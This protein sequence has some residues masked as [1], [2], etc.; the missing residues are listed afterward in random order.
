MGNKLFRTA[1]ILQRKMHFSSMNFIYFFFFL[2]VLKQQCCCLVLFVCLLNRPFFFSFSLFAC[3]FVSFFGKKGKRLKIK[4]FLRYKKISVD[5]FKGFCRS[6]VFPTVYQSFFNCNL[7][8]ANRK[9][10]F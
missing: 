1:L 4:Q 7:T 3:L 10:D 5:G 8:A 9:V 6:L 2:S